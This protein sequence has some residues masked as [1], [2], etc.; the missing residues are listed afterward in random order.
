MSVDE[1]N[2]LCILCTRR[3]CIKPAVWEFYIQSQLDKSLGI[4]ECIV[5]QSVVWSPSHA[6]APVVMHFTSTSK[7]CFTGAEGD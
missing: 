1:I 7:V 5:F 3:Q 6:A 4:S 2:A